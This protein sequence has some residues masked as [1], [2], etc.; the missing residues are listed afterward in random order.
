MRILRSALVIDGYK[1]RPVKSVIL[2]NAE[3]E[4]GFSVIEMTLFEGRNRQ[5]RKMCAMAGLEVDR[6]SRIA[7]GSLRLGDLP[8]GRWRKL[9]D[10]EIKYLKSS[11]PAQPIK[12][13][14]SKKIKRT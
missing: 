8:E 12:Q 14:N 9:T 10:A 1:I 4:R 6:L 2:K 7:Y 13:V 5:I 3:H 11:A